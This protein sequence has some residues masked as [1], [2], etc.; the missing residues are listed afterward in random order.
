[1]TVPKGQSLSR[2]QIVAALSALGA[3]LQ[4]QGHAR[5]EATHILQVLANLTPAD[6]RDAP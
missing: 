2:E 5:A 1:L 3:Q 4:A 6:A